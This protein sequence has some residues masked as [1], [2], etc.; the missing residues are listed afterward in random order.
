MANSFA[1]IYFIHDDLHEEFSRNIVPTLLNASFHG[2]IKIILIHNIRQ[3]HAPT[4][5][6][7]PFVTYRCRVSEVTRRPDG[8]LEF[9][10]LTDEVSDWDQAF[11]HAFGRLKIT[12]FLDRIGII[13]LSHSNGFVINRNGEVLPIRFFRSVLNFFKQLFGKRV[14]SNLKYIKRRTSDKGVFVNVETVLENVDG[15][16]FKSRYSRVNDN[17]CKTYEGLFVFRLASFL[18]KK[19]VT[20]ILQ[21]RKIAFYI[22][23]NCNFQLY[24]NVYLFAPIAEFIMGAQ[25]RNSST[26]WD[27]PVIAKAIQD[28]VTAGNRDISLTIFDRC[29]S[30]FIAERTERIKHYF[31]SESV[32]IRNCLHS[33]FENIIKII[34]QNIAT[35]TSY[36]GKLLDIISKL[37]ETSNDPAIPYFDILEFFTAVNE[38]SSI[39]FD[40]G[41][42][43]FTKAR[44]KVVI[45][46]FVLE[47]QLSGFSIYL[48][49]NKEEFD[50]LKAVHC[51]YFGKENRNDFSDNS[52]YEEFLTAVFR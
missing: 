16:G 7:G 8:T 4:N 31:L 48:P 28:K 37:E 14:S 15:T 25:S 42:A 6:S 52:S 43:A 10:Q 47:K 34:M 19:V 33:H 32:E 27:F 50:R 23:S 36:S 35:D 29:R 41:L 2:G 12:G 20:E 18:E 40:A 30:K 5:E 11:L 24:D 26:F 17:F 1:L 38:V 45:D 22:S 3:E 51:N 13:T 49:R 44:A 39:K 46:S 9:S 21:G